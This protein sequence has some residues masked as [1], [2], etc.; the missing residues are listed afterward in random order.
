M[1]ILDNN[2]IKFKGGPN[3][4][5]VM[6]LKL[7]TKHST[8]QLQTSLLSN[9]GALGTGIPLASQAPQFDQVFFT[10]GLDLSG[11]PTVSPFSG[12]H[13]RIIFGLKN[14]YRDQP[15]R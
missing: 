1:L 7:D 8:G 10:M 4:S 14:Q 11:A 6:L 3:A 13:S 5:G 9:I 2:G 12:E 15:R